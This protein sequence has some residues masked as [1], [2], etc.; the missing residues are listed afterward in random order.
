MRTKN[1]T[2]SPWQLRAKKIIKVE[3]LKHDISYE[4]LSE[5]MRAAGID[6]S[7]GALKTKINRGTFSAAFLLQVLDVIGCKLSVERD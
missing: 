5:L 6:E 3:M 1:L 7:A 4:Q 2:N